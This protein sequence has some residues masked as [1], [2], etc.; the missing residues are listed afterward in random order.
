MNL[1]R[2]NRNLTHRE[3][4]KRGQPYKKQHKD[5]VPVLLVRDRN[6]TEADFVFEKVEKKAI[7]DCLRPLMSDEVVLC[8]D[9]NSIYSTFAKEEEIAHKR[10]V[11]LDK[12]NVVE[13]IFHIQNLNAYISRLKTWMIRFKG[14]ATKYLENYLGWRRV[15]EKINGDLPNEFFLRQALGKNHQQLTLT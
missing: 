7:H 6:G 8:S 2:G 12:V 4:R 11:K 1:S 14:V 5:L 13:K 3:A 9:G 15:V 10:I